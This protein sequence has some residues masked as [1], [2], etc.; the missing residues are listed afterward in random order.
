MTTSRLEVDLRSVDH[1][2]AV[3]RRVIG[4]SRTPTGRPVGLCAVLKQDGYG[5]GAA[6]LAK[7][8]AAG[9]GL[10]ART[11]G[12]PGGAGGG[13][14]MFA[15]YTPDEARQLIEANITAPILVLMPMRDIT[16]VD[17][18]YRAAVAGRLAV[19]IHDIDQLAQLADLSTRLGVRLNAHVFVDT[20]LGRGGMLPEQGAEAVKRIVT[21]GGA[22]STRSG[23]AG[24][25]SLAGVMTHFASPCSDAAF[26]GE[27]ARTFREFLLGVKDLLPTGAAAPQIHAANTCAT[28]RSDKYHGTMVRVGQSLYGYGLDGVSDVDCGSMQFGM[29]GA[30][31]AGTPGQPDVLQPAVRWVS[32]VV[33]VKEIPEGH[34]VGYGS[35]WRAPRRP[36]GAATRIALIPVGYADGYP[37]SIGSGGEGGWVGFTGKRW[38]TKGE[39]AGPSAQV[40]DIVGS[41]HAAAQFHAPVVGRVSMDQITVDVTD[42][43]ANVCGVGME[44]EVAGRVSGARNFLPAVAASAGTI[45]HELLCRVS[46]RVERVYKYPAAATSLR[47]EPPPPSPPGKV[48][49]HTTGA[50]DRRTVPAAG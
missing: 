31:G 33:H 47:A 10:G 45:T 32:S 41:I 7:R 9:D 18:L 34:P 37:R 1:N 48:T 21:S 49:V 23:A 27:Q 16:R 8:L 43:P 17:P 2:V 3:I 24:R 30:G 22:P 44:V 4:Q 26:T 20:G 40:A 11:S 14:E 19:T 6:R 46:P 50:D 5:L 28:F 29:L 12:G 13:V 39:T 36:G 25:I 15:V 42:V 35:T 38:E